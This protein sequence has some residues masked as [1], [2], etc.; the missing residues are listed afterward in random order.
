APGRRARAARAVTAGLLLAI[1]ALLAGNLWALRDLHHR[2]EHLP[3]EAPPPSTRPEGTK[4]LPPAP[5]RQPDEGRDSLSRARY[6]LLAGRGGGGE[7]G[8]GKEGLLGRYEEL[9]RRH[10]DLRLGADNPRGRMAVAA[11]A[12][13]AGRSADRVEDVVRK[14]LTD[15]GFSRKLV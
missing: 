2:L 7:W 15:K 10:R 1:A 13:L 3:G 4:H 5:P 14:A 11:A 6:G 9:A 12:I 8:E